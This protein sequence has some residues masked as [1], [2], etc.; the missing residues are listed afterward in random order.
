MYEIPETT[1]W[2]QNMET[3]K[4]QVLFPEFRPARADGAVFYF[5][6]KFQHLRAY[7]GE[8]CQIILP[9]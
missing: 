3:D 9:G 4:G 7:T 1:L 6:C 8:F 2:G 5:L